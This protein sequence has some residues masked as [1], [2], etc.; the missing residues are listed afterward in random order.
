MHDYSLFQTKQ[1]TIVYMMYRMKL[2][3]IDRILLKHHWYIEHW[4]SMR[5]IL[6]NAM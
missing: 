1:I 5:V 3:E 2:N 6:C 4:N